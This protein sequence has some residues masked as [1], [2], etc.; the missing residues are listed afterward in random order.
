[1]R[2]IVHYTVKPEMA[3]EN[4]RLIKAMCDEFNVQQ[5]DGLRYAAFKGAD[6]I[7]F[8]HLAFILGDH[9]PLPN[10]VG[11]KAFKRDIAARYDDIAEPMRVREVG[12]YSFHSRETG[13]SSSGR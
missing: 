5:Y 3:G 13:E 8:Y 2:V 12:S 6:G 1:M 9:D 7:T 4:H 11:F 10:C